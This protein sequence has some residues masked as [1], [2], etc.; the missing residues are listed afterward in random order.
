MVFG[1]IVV[2]VWLSCYWLPSS[3]TEDSRLTNFSLIGTYEG[4]CDESRNVTLTDINRIIKE[5][6]G[7]NLLR[8]MRRYWPEHESVNYGMWQH[9]YNKHATCFSSGR[10][11]CY[12]GIPNNETVHILPFPHDKKETHPQKDVADYFYK[13]VDLF[14]GL[15]TYNALK[16]A[17][18]VPT[19][20]KTYTMDQ[21]QGALRATF[22]V[23][24]TVGC[25]KPNNE[26]HEMWYHF[27]VKGG[28]VYDGD[29][30]PIGKS[31]MI[32]YGPCVPVCSMQ[33]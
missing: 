13:T 5:V 4:Y 32:T 6:G 29:Y 14:K 11:E 24:A 27:H 26:L 1:L 15:N 33:Y 30:L 8:Y 12:A 19:T 23:N 18:I 10:P 31:S 25:K 20:K 21:I 3:E 16:A 28:N 2:M 17:G 22:G 9:E 7:H